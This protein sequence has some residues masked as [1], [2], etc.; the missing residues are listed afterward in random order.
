[1][2]SENQVEDLQENNEYQEES[3]NNYQEQKVEELDQNN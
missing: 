3:E 2:S 1:M